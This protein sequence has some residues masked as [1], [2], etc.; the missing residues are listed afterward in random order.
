MTTIIYDRRER[1]IVADSQNTDRS[2]ATWKT[3]KIEQLKNGWIF[4]GSGHCLPILLTRLWAEVGF[5][6]E[7]RPDYSTVLED[8][9]EYD[10]SCLCIDP[11]G[12]TVYLVDGEVAPTKVFDEYVAIGSGG[13]YALGAM[14]SGASALEAMDIA[15]GRD[16]NSSGP[17]RTKQLAKDG[18]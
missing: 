17:V 12:Q 14:D 1:V 11:T 10:F 4:L 18:D 9:D 8:L 5:Q 6:E 7:H 3:N 16:I 13:A 2:G 15:I